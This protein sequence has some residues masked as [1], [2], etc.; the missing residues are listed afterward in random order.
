MNA[1]IPARVG[2]RSS[3][4]KVRQVAIGHGHLLA[5]TILIGSDR[6]DL[7]A[8]SIPASHPVAARLVV[9]PDDVRDVGV[10]NERYDAVAP[11]GS[12]VGSKVDGGHCKSS[13]RP[14]FISGRAPLGALKSPY[15]RIRRQRLMKPSD[16]PS[17]AGARGARAGR[18]F[19]Q[20]APSER[21][22]ASR[23]RGGASHSV[24]RARASK[25]RRISVPLSLVP[26]CPSWIGPT[27]NTEAPFPTRAQAASIA[28][29][30]VS[31]TCVMLSPRASPW[32]RYHGDLTSS[33]PPRASAARASLKARVANSRFNR[34]SEG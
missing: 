20:A 27:S 15:I 7:F 25:I 23:T 30:F 8:F 31:N 32:E 28:A 9:G 1:R 18:R 14:S 4:P 12:G 24:I 21:L 10:G 19:C 3:S 2:N 26:P 11:S 17:R 16:D 34:G 29:S 33:S 5:V 13:C 6:D 22:G